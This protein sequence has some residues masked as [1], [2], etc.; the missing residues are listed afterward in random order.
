VQGT[1]VF[2]IQ[3]P[4]ASQQE[5]SSNNSHPLFRN[6][7]FVGGLEHDKGGAGRGIDMQM[8][9]Q[10]KEVEIT[11]SVEEKHR[12]ASSL[13]GDD[14][15][16]FSDVAR[17]NIEVELAFPTLQQRQFHHRI[18]AKQVGVLDKKEAAKQLGQSE[19]QSA[20]STAPSNF[21]EKQNVAASLSVFNLGHSTRTNETAEEAGLVGVKHAVLHLGFEHECPH[22]HRFLLSH[23]QVEALG[24]IGINLEQQKNNDME[25]SK[26]GQKMLHNGETAMSVS[27]NT[28]IVGQKSSFKLSANVM[29]TNLELPDGISC[30]IVNAG[31]GEGYALLNTNLPLYMMC[32]YCSKSSEKRKNSPAF[33]GNISQLQRIFLVNL[34]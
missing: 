12:F 13:T 25:S 2:P 28:M 33:A 29:G 34:S 14:K 30:K 10:S 31:S 18:I 20:L 8:H 11:V 24:S 21:E 1:T 32:P 23:E 3:V 16:L 15:R 19:L 17:S 4:E 6:F 7:S 26:N 5:D 27:T 22:G 9:K